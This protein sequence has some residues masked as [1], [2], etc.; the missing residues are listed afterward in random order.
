MVPEE[1]ITPAIPTSRV[2]I[3]A[4][5]RERHGAV[6]SALQEMPDVELRIERLKT[7]DYLVDDQCVFERKT[8]T[9][10]A[11]SVLDG[12]LF[13]QSVR[14]A[15]ASPF[16]ALILEGRASDLSE[17]RVSREA[18]QGAM[19]SLSLVYHLPVLRSVDAFETARL[20]L[21]A[22]SQMRRR[23]EACGGIHFGRRPKS[24]KRRQLRVLQALPGLG[25]E[26]AARLLEA[27]G[28]VEAVM[29]ADADALQAVTG[30]GPKTAA[31]IRDVLQEQPAPYGRGVDGSAAAG[32]GEAGFAV[33]LP[34]KANPYP[35]RSASRA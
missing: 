33:R 23:D 16:A 35:I 13:R 34:K 11:A 10:F 4:D 2:S 5:D 29:T 17:C 6:L 22:A 15:R 21:Y 8:L 9:D 27:F 26:K 31:A 14:L 25:P 20:L 3:V 18:L 32:S 7:G 30:I 12:R 24:R 28:T 1:R 19:V